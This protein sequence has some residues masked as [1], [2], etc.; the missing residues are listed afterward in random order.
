MRD[1]N[2][3]PTRFQVKEHDVEIPKT[4]FT[5]PF[6]EK[7]SASRP[8]TCSITGRRYASL[9]E[10][11]VVDSSEECI[12]RLCVSFPSPCYFQQSNMQF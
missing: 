3:N 9:L 8:M 1:A 11:S 4:C 2:H 12:E 5:G 10:Q 6:F 7:L